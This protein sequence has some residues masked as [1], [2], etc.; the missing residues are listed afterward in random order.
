MFALR[1]LRTLLRIA[2]HVVVVA[3]GYVAFMISR[4]ETRPMV[5]STEPGHGAPEQLGSRAVI[6]VHFDRKG[7]IH[8]HTRAYI[9]AL[10]D[11]G[12][13][14]VFVTNAAHL[15]TPDHD[16]IRRRAA[17]IV[18]RRN[19]GHDFAAW[20]DA[21]MACGLPAANTRLLVLANDSVY[22]PLHPL[23]PVLDRINFDEAD[24]WG[25]TDSWQHRFHL[26]SFFLA[27]GPRALGQEA[28]KQ[29]WRSV[30][31]VRSKEWVVKQYEI[32]LSRSLIAAGL[33][34][35]AIWSCLAMIDVVRFAAA[36]DE[37]HDKLEA[38][39]VPQVAPEPLNNPRYVDSLV[40]AADRRILH[41]ADHRIPLNPTADLWR[42]LVDQ[43]CPFLK[44][45]LLRVN[46][47]RVPDVAAWS[48]VLDKIEGFD[49]DIILRDLEK[50]LKNLAP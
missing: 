35:K 13:D 40:S 16:W 44:C 24:V 21:M 6:F 34:C 38:V 39:A 2:S 48:S 33:R 30:R 19:V 22:G 1:N 12:L 15:A 27:F 7:A 37:A 25:A 41:I 43:G 45:A 18:I 17:R 46:P 28:F 32:G 4:F 31:S 3:W 49:R 11:A 8:E 5:L 50:S 23:K 14:V 47:S 36:K 9:D 26:Q 42:V 20:R 10:V 29:F